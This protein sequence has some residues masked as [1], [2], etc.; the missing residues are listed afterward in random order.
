VLVEL[1]RE[2]AIAVMYEVTVGMVSRD[3]FAQLLESPLG[4]GVYGYVGM[5]ATADRMI[6]DDKHIEAAKAGCDH[7]TEII[8]HDRLRMVADLDPPALRRGAIMLTTAQRLE[9]ILRTVS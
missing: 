5:Q 1:R 7:H 4:D 9:H 6:G 8:R 3:R 2:D